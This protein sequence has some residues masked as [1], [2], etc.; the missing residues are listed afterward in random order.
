[1]TKPTK[2][3]IAWEKAFDKHDVLNQVSKK[4]FADLTAKELI[5]FREPRLMGKIDHKKNLPEIFKINNLSIMTLSRNAYRIGPFKNFEPLPG[6]ETPSKDIEMIGSS[7]NLETL[8]LQNITSETGVIHTASA[9]GMLNNFCGE[10][11]RLTVSGRMSTSKFT[12]DIDT[13][14]GNPCSIPVD[15]AQIEID[16]GF[17]GDEQFYIF[18]VKTHISEDFNLRQLYYPYR[19]WKSRIEKPV[20]PIFLTF[21]NDVFDFYQFDFEN[22]LNCSS[23]K[24]SLHRRFMLSY[25]NPEEAELV[26]IAKENRAKRRYG[27]TPFPQADD[28]KRVVDLVVIL[29]RSPKSVDELATYYGFDPRQSDYYW[30]AAKFLGLADSEKYADGIQ[31]RI[32]TV[33]AES[34]FAKPYKDKY[35]SLATLVLSVDAIAKTYLSWVNSG[36]KPTKAE[37]VTIFKNSSDSESLSQSTVERRASTILSW[38]SWLRSLTENG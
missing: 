26:K 29:L 1:M 25:S 30:N 19:T 31:Y 20:V 10:K 27:T 35:L 14:Q 11:A 7:D 36:V 21:S 4:G 22:P 8:N 2:N 33:L 17:E 6:W 37:T 18:E 5:F 12:Y 24:L 13:I 16:A 32:P 15:K 3:D 9:L 38:A 28:F 34:I 23:I